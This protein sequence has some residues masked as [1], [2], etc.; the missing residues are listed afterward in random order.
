MKDLETHLDELAGSPA[1][2][3][4]HL[5]SGRDFSGRVLEIVRSRQ[6]PCVVIQTGRRD[7]SVIPFTRIEALTLPDVIQAPG[8]VVV[9][10]SSMLE[11]RRKAKALSELRMIPI[12][13]ADGE[14]SPLAALFEAW[15]AVL[16]KVCADELGRQALADAVSRVVL[17]IGQTPGVTLADRVLTVTTSASE[18]LPPARLQAQLDA[19]L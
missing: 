16:D 13:I 6:Q 3:T 9:E 14:L 18:R 7:A 11:L 19:L 2:V 12:E 5:A 17:R 15:R 1:S 8:P 10:A 4:I